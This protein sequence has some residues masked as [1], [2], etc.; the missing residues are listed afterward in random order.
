MLAAVVLF[1]GY[2]KITRAAPFV[3]VQLD[4]PV[5]AD[6][7]GEVTAIIDHESSRALILNGDAELTGV[8]NFSVVDSPV[9]VAT[10]IC[11]SE[12]IVYVAGVKYA[13]ESELVTEERVAAY[14]TGGSLLG[15]ADNVAVIVIGL[16][17]LVCAVLFFAITRNTA[18][19]EDG[20]PVQRQEAA[21]AGNL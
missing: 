16:F 17:C 19:A 21:P 10:D 9:Q 2:G 18:L 8:V 3:P 14:D 1:V 11:V 7:D 5:A 15:V 4:R 6:S 12:G 13:P 20:A